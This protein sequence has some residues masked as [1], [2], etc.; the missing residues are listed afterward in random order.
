MGLTRFEIPLDSRVTR[1]LN[2]NCATK[3]DANRLGQLKYYESALDGVQAICEKARVLPCELDAAAF[4]Y[5]DLGLGNG[6]VLATDPGFTNPF[7]QITIRNTGRPGTNDDECAYQLAC[8]H[9]GHVYGASEGDI[10]ERECP[11]C[12][13]GPPALNLGVAS[14]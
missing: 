6:E 11:A 9:C 7:G 12:Q 1:W 14:N 5:E 3:I 2:E 8:S 10:R 13:D 4:D